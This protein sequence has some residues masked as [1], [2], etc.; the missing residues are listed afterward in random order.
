M[1]I[2][3]SLSVFMTAILATS[4]V[5]I[6][7]APATAAAETHQIVF[8]ADVDGNVP[9]M[10]GTAI[11]L[12]LEYDARSIINNYNLGVYSNMTLT[13]NNGDV[14]TI[15]TLYIWPDVVDELHIGIPESRT[16]TSEHTWPVTFSA[17][18]TVDYTI[19]CS[20]L[21][22]GDPGD[23]RDDFFEF[24][25]TAN[26][27]KTVEIL[28]C[29]YH[30]IF[31]EDT[32]YNTY[33]GGDGIWAVSVPA[34]CDNGQIFVGAYNTSGPPT[35][36]SWD[37]F[38][39]NSSGSCGGGGGP[40]S[41]NPYSLSNYFIAE[42]F[43]KGQSKLSKGMKSFI[44]KELDSVSN[45]S[46]VVCTGTVRG[47]KWTESREELALARATSACAYVTELYPDTDI[48]LKKRLMK[49]KKQDSLTVRI[50]VF[51]SRYI[52]PPA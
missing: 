14:E 41:Y 45:F 49:K 5:V 29:D 2:G 31:D 3:R 24:D 6:L 27:I 47:K 33:V 20:Q 28:N 13:F 17:D 52:A 36:V 35:S 16:A 7:E 51:N 11:Y 1:R 25:G 9:E 50:S 34:Y 42:G 19:D 23:Q 40:D 12:P 44:R 15:D 32:N 10:N 4:G 48:E 43:S 22:G 37:I 8:E 38:F 39:T 21:V 30:Y 26:L 46:K 18:I